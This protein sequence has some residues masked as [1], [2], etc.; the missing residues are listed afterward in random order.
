MVAASRGFVVG[1]FWAYLLSILATA[2]FYSGYGLLAV[3][4]AAG[5]L[6]YA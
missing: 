6:T 2:V 5:R 1:S 4:A 3:A